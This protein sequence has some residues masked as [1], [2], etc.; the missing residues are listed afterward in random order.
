MPVTITESDT[1]SDAAKLL[2]GQDVEVL[3]VFEPQGMTGVISERDMVRAVADGRTSSRVKVSD[4][5][6]EAQ[7]VSQETA[8]VGDAL[9]K[10]RV[11]GVRHVVVV[12]GKDVTGVLSLRDLLGLIKFTNHFRD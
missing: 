10:M 2:L 11:S 5:M 7:V 8:M 6:S 3:V 9:N 1:L 4:Y 12:S